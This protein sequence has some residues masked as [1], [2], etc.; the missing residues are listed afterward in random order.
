MH[1]TGARVVALCAGTL[2]MLSP[3][4]EAQPLLDGVVLPPV[5]RP[6]LQVTQ[7]YG[8]EFVT[9]TATN[10]N[11]VPLSMQPLDFQ[12]FP[13]TR[14][15]PAYPNLGQVAQPFRISRTETSTDEWVRFMRVAG[16]HLPAEVLR[17]WNSMGNLTM[18]RIGNDPADPN[19]YQVRG[20]RGQ[21]P[22]E[23]P[24]LLAMMYCNWLHNDRRTTAD[25]FQSGAY[26]TA[27]FGRATLPDGREVYTEQA[28]RSPGARFWIPSI[29]ELLL[30]HHYDPDRNGPG[31]GGW[32]MYN[33]A[34]DTVPIAGLPSEGGQTNGGG[35][36]FIPGVGAPPI[37]SYPTQNA[38]G[39]LDTSGGER[40]WTET[41]QGPWPNQT[42]Y[43]HGSAYLGS[44]LALDRLD[45]ISA[46]NRFS[47]EGLRIAAA[48]P[49]PSVAGLMA[50]AAAAWAS[51]RRDHAGV[52]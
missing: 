20:N 14:P 4:A 16:P 27:T 11:P 26:D 30:A 28:S 7:E 32:W 39:L 12:P 46:G 18:S 51:R 29:D 40:E 33:T 9:I 10:V 1:S 50:L 24:L 17:T 37:A 52:A 34:S 41:T 5:N 45:E 44:D 6:G 15:Q 49:A 43:A 19:T 47:G 25:A 31:Q 42:R 35:S 8:Y 13:P 38:W 21:L 23:A 2:M 36:L 48:V 22:I 3:C